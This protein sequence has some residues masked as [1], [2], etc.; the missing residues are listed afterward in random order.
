VSVN[1]NLPFIPV[2]CYHS[3]GPVNKN[4]NRN[5][6]TLELPF[7]EDQLRYFKEHFQPVFLKEYWNMR[8]KKQPLIKNPIVITFDDGFLDNWIWAYPLLKKYNLKATIFVCPELVDSR[9][10]IRPNL[11]DNW[12]K[13]VSYEEINQSGYLS[14]SEMNV[15]LNSGLV[16]IQS[17]TMSHTKY[18]VSDKLTGFHHPGNDCL[19]PVGNLFPDLKPYH[20]AD[21]TFEMRIPYGYPLFEEISSVSARRVTINES[22]TEECIKDLKHY[23]FDKYSFSTAFN[24][25]TELYD[26]YKSEGLLITEIETDDSIRKRLIYEIIESRRIL[27]EKLHTSI[28]FLCWPHGDNTETAHQLAINAGYLA[29]TMGSKIKYPDSLDRIPDRIGM[30]HVRNN[31]FLSNLKTRYKIGSSLGLFPYRQLNVSYNLVRY[32]KSR[33]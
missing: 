30:W 22:F 29:T 20:I 5:F 21:S 13:M 17:H 26:E 28:E 31:R 16:D 19:Y 15:M 6:L 9:E 25:V 33:I 7:F 10:V 32:G 1:K 24:E 12:K 11:E 8:S 14:W 23:N 27:E 3:I 4:W 2:V 18:F